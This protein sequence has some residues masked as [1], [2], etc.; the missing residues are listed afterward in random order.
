MEEFYYLNDIEKAEL[1]KFVQNKTQFE[2]AQKVVLHSVYFQGV[3]KE[4]LPADSGNNIFM[5]QLTQPILENAPIE[6]YGHFTKAL[7]NGIRLVETGFTKLKKFKVV[8]PETKKKI[9]RGK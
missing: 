7:V 3:L 5:A 9:N 4:G 6:E 2:A 1:E 8:E